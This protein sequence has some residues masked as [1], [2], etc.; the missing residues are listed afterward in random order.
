MNNIYIHETKWVEGEQ[1]KFFINLLE[2]AVYEQK[3]Q[4]YRGSNEL[5]AKLTF[6][7]GKEMTLDFA[8]DEKKAAAF[9][10]A[11]LIATVEIRLVPGI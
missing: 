10:R 7:C 1:S 8:K 2:I 3:V 9:E 5:Y 6:K 4:R 11:Y